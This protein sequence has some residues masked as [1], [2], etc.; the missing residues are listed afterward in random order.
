MTTRALAVPSPDL[1]AG[2]K[3]IAVGID[4]YKERK[5]NDD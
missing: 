2:D 3:I 5:C 4:L 1:T